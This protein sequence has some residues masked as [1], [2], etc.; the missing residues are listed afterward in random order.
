M[1]LTRVSAAV[2][3]DDGKC[4]DGIDTVHK[5]RVRI[6]WVGT[7]HK[8]KYTDTCHPSPGHKCQIKLCDTCAVGVITNGKDRWF[9]PFFVE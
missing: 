1:G 3:S 7:A 5:C 6:G 9:I 4:R 8:L 2:C